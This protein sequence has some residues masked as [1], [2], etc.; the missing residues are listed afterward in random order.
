MVSFCRP[1]EF[2]K[3]SYG[4]ASDSE[5]EESRVGKMPSSDE[6]E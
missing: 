2:V 4:S 6:D 5:E 1:K 3:Q